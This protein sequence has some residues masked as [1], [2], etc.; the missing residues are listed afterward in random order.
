MPSEIS[1]WRL[2]LGRHLPA[3]YK[4]VGQ[5]HILHIN[6]PPINNKP[7]SCYSG[8]KRLAQKHVEN[9]KPLVHGDCPAIALGQTPGVADP[10]SHMC[11][12]VQ[13]SPIPERRRRLPPGSRHA[14]H[15]NEPLPRPRWLT[16]PSSTCKT[17]T[18][19]HP[20]HRS[21]AWNERE[22]IGD[23]AEKRGSRSC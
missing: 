11:P 16:P 21:R 1:F 9:P 7:A 13:L 23:L 14:I 8:V 20:R 12:V 10:S 4:I 5:K 17:H 15:A 6:Q 2:R 18:K 22:K 3:V 19:G